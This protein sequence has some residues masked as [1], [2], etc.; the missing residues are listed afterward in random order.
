MSRLNISTIITSTMIDLAQKIPNRNGYRSHRLRIGDPKHIVP[1]TYVPYSGCSS[2]RDSVCIS[3]HICEGNIQRIMDDVLRK[4]STNFLMEIC[5]F[6]LV[7]FSPQERSSER[8]QC[9]VR[10]RITG[11]TLHR[12]LNE[13]FQ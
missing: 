12:V 9:V 6:F 2:I 3:L 7:G 4:V 13:T 11:Q 1:E 5:S 8:A 10:N